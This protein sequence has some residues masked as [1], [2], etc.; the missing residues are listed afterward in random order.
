MDKELGLRQAYATI[1]NAYKAK[2]RNP[3]TTASDLRSLVPVVT[4]KTQ[5]TFPII[6]GDDANNYPEA[7]LLNRADAFTAV[8]IGIF[9]GAKSSVSD[10]A[11]DWFTY[12][13][14]TIFTASGAATAFKTLFN[15]S[16]LNATIN[17][18][19]YLQNYSVSRLRKAPI[20]QTGQT[21]G[22]GYTT[23]GATNVAPNTV[24][25]FNGTT[26]GFYPLVP[27]LQLSGT[28]KIDITLNLSSGLTQASSGSYVIALQVRGFLSLGASNLN[29]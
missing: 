26:D 15:N 29:K 25:S 8:E 28:S 2:Q 17:N 4:G 7:I 12:P 21:Y 22:Y 3:V 11:Y 14:A 16:F 10:T 9:I 6:V 24:D 20:V 27:T 19:Q 18:V 5:Y 1:K 23:T 13:N